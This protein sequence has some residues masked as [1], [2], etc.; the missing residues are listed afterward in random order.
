MIQ[1]D[2]S[3]VLP[4]DEL[5]N[6]MISG[7]IDGEKTEVKLSEIASISE[8]SSPNSIHRD[9][10]SRTV[11]ASAQIQSGYNVGLV[12]QEFEKKL[13]N[14]KVPEG[15]S[16]EIDGENTN[17]ME[18]MVE[19]I[20]AIVLAIIFIYLIMVAQFQSLLLPFIILFIIPISF[21]GG[22]LG[23]I[24]TGMD[25]SI[26]AM[27]GLLILSGIIVNNGI[28]FIDYVNQLRQAGFDKR[29]ALIQTGKTRL[30]PI[31]MTATT[32]ILGLL[33]LA[34]GIG[35]GSEMLQPMAIVTV[36][37]LI[38][39]TFMTLFI[40]P[41]LYDLLQRKSVKKMILEG[42]TEEIHEVL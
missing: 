8:G 6:F 42:E 7:T 19:V 14:Y 23:L 21:T 15:Y 36:G 13:E 17:I 40:I 32:T 18:T 35:D 5:P 39:G 25:V 26:I 2:Q 30:R 12:S 31:I 38:Y 20:L 34:L 33:A 28:V 9:N 1:G 37:G 29:E 11:T 10:Q 4:Q 22:F 27:M 16:I 24:L 41:I 3:T